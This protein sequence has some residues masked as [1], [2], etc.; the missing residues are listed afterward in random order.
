MHRSAEPLVESVLAGKDLSQGSVEQEFDAQIFNRALM[1][2]F[3]NPQRAASD[4]SLHDVHQRLVIE[5][6]NGR[7]PLGQDFPMAPVGSENKVVNGEMIGHPDCRCLLADGQV[8]RARMVVMD[9]GIV[10]RGLDLVEHDLKFPDNDHVAVYPQKII[11]CVPV[12]FFSKGLV[13]L[14]ERY[15]PE[16]QVIRHPNLLR[17]NIERSGHGIG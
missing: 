8:G 2:L 17:I 6:V 10:V 15:F 14:I 3:N 11:I 13:V 4:K 16:S 9:T 1:T 12:P 5:L 7:E